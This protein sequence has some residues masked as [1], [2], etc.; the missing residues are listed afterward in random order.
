MYFF[1]HTAGHIFTAVSSLLRWWKLLPDLAG[2]FITAGGGTPRASDTFNT[3]HDDYGDATTDSFV[4]AS[5]A[6]DG[7]LALI[8]LSHAST[9]TIDQS[10]LQAGYTA[11]WIDPDSGASYA[12]TAGATYNSGA[13]DGSKPVNNSVGDPDWVLALVG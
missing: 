4:T 13:A 3:D 1:V 6:P 2:T 7:S 10:K 9:I 5:V 8:Y 12:G 11:K